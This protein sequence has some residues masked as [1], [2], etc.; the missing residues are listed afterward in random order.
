[1]IWVWNNLRVINNRIALSGW[2]VPLRPSK[3]S[4]NGANA[5]ASSVQVILILQGNTSGFCSSSG[6]CCGDKRAELRLGLSTKIAACTLSWDFLCRSTYSIL[7]S[8]P[9]QHKQHSGESDTV[10][11]QNTCNRQM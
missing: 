6:L 10:R 4:M 7:S 8:W 5:V 9:Q 11:Q 1:M 3:F 2:T